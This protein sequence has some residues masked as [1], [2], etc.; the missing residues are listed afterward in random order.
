MLIQSIIAELTVAICQLPGGHDT[1]QNVQNAVTAIKEAKQKNPKV[2]LAIL[3]E[4][5]N[6]PYAIE[7]FAKTAEKVP[8]G[9]TCQALSKLAQSLGIY[10]IGGSIIERADSDKLYNTCPVFSPEGKLIGRHR[11]VSRNDN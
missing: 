11:K 6:G 8:E 1:K 4:C 2:Q 7:C 3:P 5:F 9:P 10:I